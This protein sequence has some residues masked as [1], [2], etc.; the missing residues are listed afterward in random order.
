MTADTVDQ[1]L[2]AIALRMG[3]GVAELVEQHVAMQLSAFPHLVSE[4]Q[5]LALL[6][7]AVRESI[8]TELDHVA[9]GTPLEELSAPATAAEWTRRIAQRG[10]PLSEVLRG[11]RLSQSLLLQQFLARIADA[12]ADATTAIGAA[13]RIS[14][15]SFALYDRVFSAQ[16]AEAYERERDRWE[17]TRTA[18]RRAA[19]VALLARGTTDVD[20]S[21]RLLGRR[22]RGAHVGLVAWTRAASHPAPARADGLERA[23]RALAGRLGHREPPLCVRQDE[24]TLWAWLA[25]DPSGAEVEAL[26]PQVSPD[27]AAHLAVGEPGHG[28]AGFR[29]SHRQALQA[30]AVAVAAEHR[31]AHRALAYRRA[32]PVAML[33]ADLEGARLWVD[34]T[35]GELARDTPAAARIRTTLRVFLASGGSYAA[36]ARE[37][38]LHRNTVKYRVDQAAN[39]CAVPVE[40]HRLDVELALRAC[41]LLGATVLRRGRAP[42]PGSFTSA[43]RSPAGG[44]SAVR[45]AGDGA[46]GG[47]AR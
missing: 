36:A 34:A 23:V 2:V 33:C 28:V 46:K 22:L 17:Q 8:T 47:G 16:I 39:L 4:D 9:H 31:P 44:R 30:L 11:Y 15:R 14:E 38:A 27:P 20:A 32:G 5:L 6:R 1:L 37:L 25:G 21:E 13:M 18:A 10:D 26:W 3:E 35:L 12:S 19:V 29:L 24:S 43:P 40:D 7:S 41:D 42:G 45:P